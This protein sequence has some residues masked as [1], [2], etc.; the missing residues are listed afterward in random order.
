MNA[1]TSLMVDCS[2]VLPSNFADALTAG[3]F[4]VIMIGDEILKR[5]YLH[6]E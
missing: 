2:S 3:R 4:F 5:G 6:V 1:N